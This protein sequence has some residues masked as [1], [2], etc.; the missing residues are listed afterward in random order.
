VADAAPGSGD[1]PAWL[2]GWVAV[3]L[4]HEIQYRA[5]SSRCA[6]HCVQY[7]SPIQLKHE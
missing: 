1:G 2:E 7:M 5:E 4:P 6:P 3:G